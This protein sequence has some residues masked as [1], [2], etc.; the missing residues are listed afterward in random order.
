MKVQTVEDFVGL[1][2]DL[3]SHKFFSVLYVVEKEKH[4]Y[5]IFFTK[6]KENKRAGARSDC[7]DSF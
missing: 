5:T 6:C 2:I 7:I 1:K 3:S 4:N